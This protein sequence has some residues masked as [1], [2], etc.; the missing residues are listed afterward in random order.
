MFWCYNVVLGCQNV[1]ILCYQCF[2]Y[3][4]CAVLQL[5][6]CAWCLLHLCLLCKKYS[7]PYIWHRFI[8][9]RKL[10]LPL[11]T[12]DMILKCK[13]SK[14]DMGL[15]WKDL[16]LNSDVYKNCPTTGIFGK[17][18][19]FFFFNRPYWL[20]QNTWNTHHV[21]QKTIFWFLCVFFKLF[22]AGWY[23]LSLTLKA[24]AGYLFKLIKRQVF[25]IE[26]TPEWAKDWYFIICVN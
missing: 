5:L 4:L 1:A 25:T 19:H 26:T 3:F 24:Q 23:P 17:H 16:R 9:Q 21:L 15:Q 2:I 11:L 18:I 22:N 20:A 14:F 7:D 10:Y 13:D 8:T 12:Q 6:R